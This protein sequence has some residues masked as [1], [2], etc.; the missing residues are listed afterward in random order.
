MPVVFPFLH[1]YARMLGGEPV[2]VIERLEWLTD[3]ISS[4]SDYE[5][6]IDLRP[7]GP[8]RIFEYAIPLSDARSR[9]VFDNLTHTPNQSYYVPVCS[10]LTVTTGTAT[11]SGVNL[12]AQYRD[13]DTAGFAMLWSNPWTYD[14]V[15]ITGTSSTSISYSTTLANSWPAGSIIVP[16]RR[17]YLAQKLSGQ[18]HLSNVETVNCEFHVL[19]EEQSTNRFKTYTRLTHKFF[20]EFDFAPASVA[21]VDEQPYTIEYRG[22]NLDFGTGVFSQRSQ[23]TGASKTLRVRLLFS[24][25]ADMGEFLDWLRQTSGR[26]KLTWVPSFQDDLEYLSG[27]GSTIKVRDDGYL[28]VWQASP[29]R[30]ELWAVYNATF[31]AFGGHQGVSAT[32]AVS[33]GAGGVDLTLSSSVTGANIKF[34]SFRHLCRLNSDTVDLEWHSRGRFLECVLEFKEINRSARLDLANDILGHPL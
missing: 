18:H 5:Q 25:R 33:D 22:A 15:T 10:D 6:R 19:A 23:D 1:N 27:T 30:R 16:M 32:N 8:R 3:I 4:H 28:S 9:R 11:N 34:I 24:T 12:D 17:A 14:F 2:P 31:G 26:Q 29:A 13:F 20:Y 7:A 21:W